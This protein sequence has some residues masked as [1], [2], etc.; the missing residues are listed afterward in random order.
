MS[1]SDEALTRA[2]ALGYVGVQGIAL[3]TAGTAFYALCRKPRPLLRYARRLSNLSRE[4]ILPSYRGWAT[5]YRGWAQICQRK[6]EE[7]LSQMRTGLEQLQSTGTGGS[8]PQL[9]TFMAEAYAELGE[10]RQGEN[11]IN[12]AL[13]LAAATGA[14]SHLAEMHRVRGVLY[15]K[16]AAFDE[17][18]DA[19]TRAIDVAREQGTRLWELRATLS[20]ARLWRARGQAAEAHARLSEIYGWFTEGFDIPDLV[21]ARAFLNRSSTG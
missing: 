19:F 4:H 12:R 18:E 13:T 9:L 16:G 7:G 20:L 14:R 15:V 3:T 2:E 1:M 11:A 8:V 10:I 21:A 17:T 5:S 6:V